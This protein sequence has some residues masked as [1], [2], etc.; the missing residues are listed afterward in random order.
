MVPKEV[1]IHK[2][3]SEPQ[4]YN[5]VIGFYLYEPQKGTTLEPLGKAQLSGLLQGVLWELWG[6]FG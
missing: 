6:Y 2:Y 4:N 1:P 3:F 5:P